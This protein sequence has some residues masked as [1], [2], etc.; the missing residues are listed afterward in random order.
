MNKLLNRIKH[1]VLTLSV[2][3]N[4]NPKKLS[5]DFGYCN[6]DKFIKD[7]S[8]LER[9][10]EEWGMEIELEVGIINVKIYENPDSPYHP[11]QQVIF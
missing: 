10:I 2:E 11:K 9:S 4:D 5:Q 7:L 6:K 8:K 1:Q 3:I